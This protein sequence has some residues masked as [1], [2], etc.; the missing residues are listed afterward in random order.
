MTHPGIYKSAEGARVLARQY[1]ALLD[2][3]PVPAQYLDIPTRQGRTFVVASGPPDAP[4]LV[5]LHGSGAN[6]AMWAED[7]ACWAPHFRILAVDVIGEPGLSAPARPPL[8]SDA[9]ALWL[10]DVLDRLGVDRAA[11]VGTSLGGR[12]ALDYA[13]RRPERVERLVL[14]CPSG[15]GRQKTAVLAISLLLLPL[16]RWGRRTMLKLAL[17]PLPPTPARE[18]AFGEAVLLIHRHF[19]P[20][21]ERIPVIDDAALAALPM[22]VHATLGARDRL[23]DSRHTARRLQRSAPHATVCLLPGEGHLLRGLAEPTLEALLAE[24]AR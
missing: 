4:P 15:I 8:A 21:R 5:L 1:T 14:R 18:H 9:H 23:L 22:P 12:L 2:R 24:A 6:S 3:W 11:F 17:G 10:D 16:G 19:R 13:V 7:V 20:R